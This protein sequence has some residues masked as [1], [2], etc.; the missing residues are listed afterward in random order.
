MLQLSKFHSTHILQTSGEDSNC[1]MVFFWSIFSFFHFFPFKICQKETLSLTKPLR[2]PPVSTAFPLSPPREVLAQPREL[3][4]DDACDADYPA[5]PSGRGEGGRGG[6][7]RWV[8]WSERGGEVFSFWGFLFWG[9]DLG[10][11]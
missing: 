1:S 3:H 9:D 11:R 5:E 2:F 4:A 10:S 7:G 8:T 6:E